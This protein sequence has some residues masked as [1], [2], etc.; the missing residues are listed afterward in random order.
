MDNLRVSEEIDKLPRWAVVTLAVRCA[1]RVQPLLSRTDPGADPEEI[2]LIERA[3]T[4]AGTSA[5]E[6]RR[7]VEP[8]GYRQAIG[9]AIYGVGGVV[10]VAATAASDAVAASTAEHSFSVRM[11]ARFACSKA[12]E[13]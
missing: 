5:W 12:A 13:A 8:S 2:G 3:I 7:M 4:L 10:G 6:G 1:R 9:E 11:S